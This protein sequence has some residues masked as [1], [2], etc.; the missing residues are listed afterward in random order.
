M[1]WKQSI[2]ILMAEILRMAIRACLF[3][4]GILIALASVW[5]C[6]R[7]LHF[8]INWLNRVLFD[9]PW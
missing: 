2:T 9:S 8:T 6:F 1:S 4:D 3:I 7:V 5:F